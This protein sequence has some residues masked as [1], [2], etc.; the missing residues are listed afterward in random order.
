LIEEIQNLDIDAGTTSP[1]V[2]KSMRLG[3]SM[4]K[5][6][7]L[8]EPELQIEENVPL[9]SAGNSMDIVLE[10]T[11]TAAGQTLTINKYFANA[12]TVDW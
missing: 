5:S 10:A 4:L 7:G 3:S 9:R 12:Y 11:V 2:M 1:M 6:L 8:V